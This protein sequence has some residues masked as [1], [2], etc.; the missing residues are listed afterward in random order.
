MEDPNAVLSSM[1]DWTEDAVVAA[2]Q[3]GAEIDGEDLDGTPLIITAVASRYERVVRAMLEKGVDCAVFDPES[4]LDPF[5]LALTIEAG[6]LSKLFLEKGL[7]PDVS[8]IA[9][10]QRFM[11]IPKYFELVLRAVPRKKKRTR[12]SEERA[13]DKELSRVIS[14]LMMNEQEKREKAAELLRRG[15]DPDVKTKHKTPLLTFAALLPDP[16]LFDL[17]LSSGADPDARGSDPGWT[18][19][20]CLVR[21]SRPDALPLLERLFGRGADLEAFDLH[22]RTALMHAAEES[23]PELVRYL[24]SKG[25]RCDGVDGYGRSALAA[26][27]SW[28][29]AGSKDTREAATVQ[30]VETLLAAG[31]DR[32]CRDVDGK[33]A[34]DVAN[35]EGHRAAGALERA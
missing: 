26:A 1:S 22:G 5:G 4:G 14:L 24:L 16:S 28:Q 31:A 19:A 9:R 8:R 25:A 7:K 27:V 34:L 17:A 35:A 21:Q 6:A 13:L 30:I 3:A 10:L 20:M 11:V 2:L 12:T 33:T 29:G 15:A 23:K 18:T 32:A